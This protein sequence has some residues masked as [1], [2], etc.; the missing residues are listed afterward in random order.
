MMTSLDS[1]MD[2]LAKL[3]PVLSTLET[4]TERTSDGCV[5]VDSILSD[6]TRMEALEDE[7][8]LL[9]PF[10][11]EQKNTKKKPVYPSVGKRASQQRKPVW[12][13]DHTHRNRYIRHQQN[14]H[15]RHATLP[16]SYTNRHRRPS[17]PYRRKAR[18]HQCDLGHLEA[19][20]TVNSNQLMLCKRW[21]LEPNAQRFLLY[22][23]IHNTRGGAST[24]GNVRIIAK[25]AK[26]MD[27]T[28]THF[29]F[30]LRLKAGTAL[31]V[32]SLPS[33]HAFVVLSTWKLQPAGN[34]ATAIDEPINYECSVHHFT[35]VDFLRRL[36]L[37]NQGCNCC[38]CHVCK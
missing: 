32:L 33:R 37:Q 3:G 7:P 14:G 11:A 5:D 17:T 15:N 27:P 38:L 9:A 36:Q 4:P 21:K 25:T 2:L 31:D 1:M 12:G 18:Q 35:G 20:W 26:S 28:E 29:L 6:I 34:F 19:Q 10:S 30:Q 13:E 16:T 22:P 23:A 24:F 8:A